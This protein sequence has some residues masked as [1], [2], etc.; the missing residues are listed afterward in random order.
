MDGIAGQ[1]VK[2]RWPDPLIVVTSVG[3]LRTA[4]DAMKVGAS[5]LP[6]P[7]TARHCAR[8]SRSSSAGA[9]AE[10]ACWWLNLELLGAFAVS[11][12]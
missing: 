1:R 12:C 8:S 2:E 5:G 6:S 10:L 9:C 3:D 11:A 7:S 4:I